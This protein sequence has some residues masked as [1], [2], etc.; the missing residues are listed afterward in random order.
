MTVDILAELKRRTADLHRGIE[1]VVPLM[2]PAL[3]LEQYA[4]YL[5]RLY[6]FYS[7]V[8]ARLAAITGLRSAV[9]DLDARWKTE[10]LARD[11]R[12]LGKLPEDDMDLS[13]VPELHSVPQALGCLYVLEGST[14][15]AQILIRS[16]HG[17]LGRE[18]ED[19]TGFLAGYGE[20]TAFRWRQLSGCLVSYL[21]GANDRETAVIAARATFMDLHEWLVRGQRLHQ[22]E[23]EFAV[24]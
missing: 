8:E 20:N 17:T 16:V 10:I 7:A 11:L 13:L 12:A 4:E 14:L 23:G 1:A 18:V 6:P 21:T 5:G 15:G 3:T 22:Y 2:A 9:P 19:K 24:R